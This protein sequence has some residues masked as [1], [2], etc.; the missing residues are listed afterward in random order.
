MNSVFLHEQLAV[1]QII[2]LLRN[3]Q[4]CRAIDRIIEGHAGSDMS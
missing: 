4:S 3:G 2:I 1:V